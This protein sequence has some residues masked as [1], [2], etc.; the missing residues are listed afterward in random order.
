MTSPRFIR[1][2][3]SYL[4]HWL[5]ET[6]DL[7]DVTI[8]RLNPDFPGLLKIVELGLML[9]ETRPKTAELILQCFFW[10]EQVGYVP[11]WQPLVATAIQR[12]P[13]QNSILHFR[14]L[15]QLG[16]L[17][18][19]QHQLDTAVAT[20][21]QAEQLAH[22]LADDQAVAE[23]HMNFCQVFH[24]QGK[25]EA[26]ETY[27]RLALDRLPQDLPKLRGIILRTLGTVAQ[28]QGKWGLAENY[29]QDALKTSFVLKE[30]T[31][32]LN[33][34][35]VNFQAQAQYDQALDTYDELLTLMDSD[36]GTTLFVY[37]LL[38]KG[39]LLHDLNHLDKAE[40]VF[41]EAENLLRQRPGMFFLKA[42]TANNLG[43]IWRD[44]KQFSLAEASFRRS[45]QQFVQVGSEIY[46]A[47]AWGNLAKLYAQQARTNEAIVCYDTALARVSN[48]SDNVY[49][50]KLR[51]HYTRSRDE[52]G[53]PG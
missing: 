2:L 18:R 34:L 3:H 47:N 8:R 15:K 12:V 24:L 29:L 11:V 20:L 49:A 48:Y 26:A 50:Q 7:D 30:R 13:T 46:E 6:A 17:Q 10:V 21:Q 53:Q 44:Q 5:R 22:V 27:G 33:V 32:T 45:I 38:N 36:V 52:L 35:A 40:L 25:Y 23:I 37:V 4:D 16:Q 42:L 14:L 43:C 9:P 41:K 28:E 31:L 51:T 39:S 19:L 1:G